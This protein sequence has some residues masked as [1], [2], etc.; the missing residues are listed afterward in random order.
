[1][2]NSRVADETHRLELFYD[3]NNEIIED[4]PQTSADINRFVGEYNH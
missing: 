2:F 4:F 3:V 1:M